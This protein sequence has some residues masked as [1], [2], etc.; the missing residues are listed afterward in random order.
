MPDDNENDNKGGDT[1]VKTKPEKFFFNQNSFDDPR[2]AENEDEPPP[3]VFSEEEL[4]AAKVEAYKKGQD[5]ARQEER[6]TREQKIA[7]IAEKIE[8]S[9]SALFS[10][11]EDRK[12]LYEAESVHLTLHILRKLFPHLNETSGLDEIE[13]VIKQALESQDGLPSIKIDVPPYTHEGIQERLHNT[14]ERTSKSGT[15]EITEAAGL[16]TGDCEI[17]WHNGGALRNVTDLS[18]TIFALLESSLEGR[19]LQQ[20]E[21]PEEDTEGLEEK[22]IQQDDTIAETHDIM[23][24]NSIQSP[25]DETEQ[26]IKP[27][28][29]DE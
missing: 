25:D 24:K 12:K 26:R 10:Q 8:S 3:P 20:E 6:A 18:N 11:E 27:E 9:L 15:I 16:N 7:D 29:D 21:T 19:P 5:Q 1:I 17:K 28:T 4:E 13:N 22:I 23:S 14:I 2:S